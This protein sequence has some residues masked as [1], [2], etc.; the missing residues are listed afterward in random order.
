MLR[1]FGT[2]RRRTLALFVLQFAALGIIASV[3][4]IALALIGQSL[5]V[6][7][8]ASVGAHRAAGPRVSCRRSRPSA[9]AVLLLFGF[10]LPPL[11]RARE[12]AAAARPAART[13][14]RPRPGG[15]FAYLLG[16]ASSRS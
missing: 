5:L 8:L 15:I 11:D 6:A 16:A 13:S 2:S 7:L 4:G 12:R 10:A 9:P 1:C 14:Q 3:A